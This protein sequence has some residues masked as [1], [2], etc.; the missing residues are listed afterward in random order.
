VFLPFVRGIKLSDNSY[1]FVY[2][3]LFNLRQCVYAF[4]REVII[5]GKIEHDGPGRFRVGICFRR[6]CFGSFAGVG[7]LVSLGLGLLGSL[8]LAVLSGIVSLPIFSKCR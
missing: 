7:L 2:V 1:S 3:H 8:G 4:I 6:L 5:S